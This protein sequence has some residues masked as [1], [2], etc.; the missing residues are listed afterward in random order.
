MALEPSFL[1]FRQNKEKFVKFLTTFV[2]LTTF[3]DDCLL[4]FNNKYWKLFLTLN[5]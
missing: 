1:G 4:V 3:F 5:I 2:S